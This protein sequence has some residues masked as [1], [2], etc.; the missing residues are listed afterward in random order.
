LKSIESLLHLLILF[1]RVSLIII[2]LRTITVA[3]EALTHELLVLIQMLGPLL[4]DLV[5]EFADM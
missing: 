3:L 4:V 1:I 5:G 2:V